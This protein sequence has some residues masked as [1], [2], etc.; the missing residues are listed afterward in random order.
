MDDLPDQYCLILAGDAACYFPSEVGDKL[1]KNM[2]K[3][4]RDA[5]AGK[6][7]G[8]KP[9]RTARRWTARKT[10]T[11]RQRVRRDGALVREA[12]PT[13]VQVVCRKARQA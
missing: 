11:S 5:E 7:D 4:K 6:E 1:H 13:E 9:R 12:P 10:R 3:R 8:E 2:L